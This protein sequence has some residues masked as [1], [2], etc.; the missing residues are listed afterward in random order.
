MTT[1]YNNGFLNSRKNNLKR[2]KKM[3]IGIPLCLMMLG[4]TGLM[5]LYSISGGEINEIVRSHFYRLIIGF[6]F[7]LFFS[8]I[9]IKVLRIISF[10]IYFFLLLMLCYLYFYDISS[11]SRWISIAD[12]SFQPSEF[13]KFVLILILSSY[14]SFI[15]LNQSKKLRFNL[16]PIILILIPSFLILNQPDLGTA[17]LIIIIGF[18][19]VFFS[20]L[21]LKW[22]ILGSSVFFISIPIILTSLK[23]YQLKR[24]EVFLDPDKD[25]FGSGYHI[26]QSKIAIGSGG[27]T[28]KGLMSG[29]QSQLNFLPEKYNDFIM[30]VLLEETGLIGGLFVFSIFIYFI[31]I[32]IHTAMITRS[33]FCSIACG[34][35]AVLIFLYFFI[36]CAMI[37]GLIPIV[38]VPVPMLSY[39]GTAVISLC[40]AMGLVFNARRKRDIKLESFID[41]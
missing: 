9:S 10:P 31:T 16:I 37:I 2:L 19:A 32:S 15:G 33:R 25:P 34:S 4:F 39:G 28:G 41:A 18:S 23:P 11:V 3:N 40:A 35:I 20:G 27:L 26:I 8:F 21:R 30:A 12:I 38:G 13:L 14:Y 17:I 29:T 5:M 24:L 22:V 6:L 7:F 36:N 1:I